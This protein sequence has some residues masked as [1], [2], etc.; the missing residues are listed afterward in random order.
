MVDFINEHREAYGVESICS[1]LPIAP[2]TYYRAVDL[3]EHPEKRSERAKNDES[4][5]KRILTVW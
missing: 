4:L 2:S 3:I 5:S 1:Q